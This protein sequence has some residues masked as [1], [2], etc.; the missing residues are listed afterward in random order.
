MLL[1]SWELFSNNPRLYFLFCVLRNVLTMSTQFF[2]QLNSKKEHKK[3]PYVS[4]NWKLPHNITMPH[5]TA[6]IKQLRPEFKFT[7]KIKMAFSQMLAI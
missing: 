1:R 7:A 3:S 2:V 5:G 4:W 6:V